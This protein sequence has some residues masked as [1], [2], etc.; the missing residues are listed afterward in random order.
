M[1]KVKRKIEE[2]KDILNISASEPQEFVINIGQFDFSH[3]ERMVDVELYKAVF[4]YEKPPGTQLAVVTV[5]PHM[6]AR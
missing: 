2:V 1:Y 3:F 5:Y 4:I 6:F